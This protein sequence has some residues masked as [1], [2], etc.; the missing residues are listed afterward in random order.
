MPKSRKNPRRKVTRTPQPS[1]HKKVKIKGLTTRIKGKFGNGKNYEVDQEMFDFY[2]PGFLMLIN[3]D[4]PMDVTPVKIDVLTSC[5]LEVLDEN[6]LFGKQSY[7]SEISW[8][9]EG[10]CEE[11]HVNYVG[12]KYNNGVEERFF[13]SF[14]SLYEGMVLFHIIEIFEN[15]KIKMILSKG[16]K[17]PTKMSN[18]NLESLAQQ[19]LFGSV[20]S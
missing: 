14:C 4:D 5:A 13:Y 17:Q 15:G 6:S 8:T 3:K 12:V 18:E 2:S 1:N 9:Y 19:F 20:Q 10:I 16:F 7:A 11:G